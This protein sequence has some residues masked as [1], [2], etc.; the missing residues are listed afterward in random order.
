M[1]ETIKTLKTIGLI[2]LV[3]GGLTA[4]GAAINAIIPWTMIV[5]VMAIFRRLTM[6]LDFTWDIDGAFGLYFWL[7][8]VLIVLAAYWIYRAYLLITSRLDK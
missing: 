6:Y 4:L 1:N 2:G 7:T 8:Q 5:T 3:I